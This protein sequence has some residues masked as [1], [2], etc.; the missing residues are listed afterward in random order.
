MIWHYR[1]DER[2]EAERG[3]EPSVPLSLYPRRKILSSTKL[4]ALL[5]LQPNPTI[6]RCG[7]RVDKNEEEEE[8]KISNKFNFELL[9][10]ARQMD[11][12]V[13]LVLPSNDGNEWR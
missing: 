1:F 8:L 2:R 10:P 11:S 13:L 5:L 6:K 7:V 4:M 9:K 12:A 3:E